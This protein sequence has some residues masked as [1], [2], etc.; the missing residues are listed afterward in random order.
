MRSTSPTLIG[1]LA[2]LVVLAVVLAALGDG[3]AAGLV[4]FVGVVV[5]VFMVPAARRERG[6]HPR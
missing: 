1:A 4:V 3:V 5:L 2:A 6:Q